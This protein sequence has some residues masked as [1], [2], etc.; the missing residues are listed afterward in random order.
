MES[1]VEEKGKLA[2]E[3]WWE[4][5]WA[6][7]SP[8]VIGAGFCC[9]LVGPRRGFYNKLNDN[10]SSLRY[11]LDSSFSWK[12]VSK[13]K[14]SQLGVFVLSKTLKHEPPASAL[15][16]FWVHLI[17]AADDWTIRRSKV[18]SPESSP[19]RLSIDEHGVWLPWRVSL[20]SKYL[21]RSSSV[22]RLDRSID[23][24]LPYRAFLWHS[25]TSCFSLST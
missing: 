6:P 17:G 3:V 4:E 25:S 1:V 14:I 13:L 5:S 23:T 8:R 19:I 15:L 16:V 12:K 21:L 10:S 20:S 18:P 9:W 2:V 7:Q 22:S 11:R 24:F